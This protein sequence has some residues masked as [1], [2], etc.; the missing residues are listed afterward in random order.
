VNHQSNQKIALAFQR[1]RL[2]SE[3]GDNVKNP[4]GAL[5]SPGTSSQFGANIG[6]FGAD[7]MKRREANSRQKNGGAAQLQSDSDFN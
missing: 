5:I 2:N 6:R 1:F 3:A 4:I 7:Y